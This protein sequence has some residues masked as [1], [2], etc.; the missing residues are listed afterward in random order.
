M[1]VLLLDYLNTPLTYQPYAR[2][3]LLEY[4][5]KAPAGTRIAIFALTDRLIMLQGFTSDMDVL[6]NALLSKKGAPQASDILTD[7][8]NGGAMADSTLSDALAYNPTR[9]GHDYPGDDRRC[10]PV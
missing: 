2:K 6:K 7:P 3:Q 10:R 1:N 8:V 4:L 9:S 5:S